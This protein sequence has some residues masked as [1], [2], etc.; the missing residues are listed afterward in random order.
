MLDFQIL[1]PFEVHRDGE[2]LPL[3]GRQQRALLAALVL[4]ANELVSSERLI[5][6]LW[7]EDPPDTADHLVHVY[8][9]RLRKALGDEGRDVLVT[10][11]P[12]YELLVP[13]GA[14]DLD[15]FEE[16]LTRARAARDVGHLDD[17]A[18]ALRDALALWRGPALADLVSESFARADAARLNELRIGAVEDLVEVELA[19]GDPDLVPQL[20][21]LVEE[22]PLRERLRGF[23][24]VALYREGRQAEALQAY[25]EARAT[26]ADELGIDPSQELQ[27]LYR[28]VLNQDPELRIERPVLR[29]AVTT[30]DPGS[31]AVASEIPGAAAPAP[32]PRRRRTVLVGGIGVL[33]LLVAAG[34]VAVLLGG[35]GDGTGMAPT[36]EVVRI[37]SDATDVLDRL[38][39]DGT[40]S[41]M[42]IDG[43]ILWIADPDARTITRVDTR[44]GEGRPYSA[45]GVPYAI[46]A[47]GGRAWVMDP[48][49]GTVTLIE[50]DASPR[51]IRQSHA[52]VDAVYA[53]DALWILD[54]IDESVSKI[55]P[56]SGESLA[57]IDLES[58]SGPIEIDASPDAIWVLNAL[59]RSLARIDPVTGLLDP[60]GVDL[61]CP[62]SA[63]GCR[64]SHLAVSD[65]LEWVTIEHAGTVELFDEDG[66]Q[67]ISVEG[68]ASPSQLVAW[69]E[70]AWI[71]MD[72]GSS[73]MHLDVHARPA[74]EWHSARAILGVASDGGEAWTSLAPP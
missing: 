30:A 61:Y 44:T 73:L 60:L 16:H 57:R 32:S 63:P 9:S 6:E 48:F 72:G 22:H 3:G 69:N 43:P 47:A 8:V 25:E 4:R 38:P 31:P 26:L 34:T 50:G 66:Q 59:D 70:G 27:D 53:F 41:A 21:S 37:S 46:E 55:D 7:P 17:A 54:A 62:P 71:V 1:G 64:P 10:R 68:W 65:D 13:A 29:A 40:P 19:R 24:M 12:G 42:T 28:R 14:R 52:P 49:G 33:A 51:V 35:D 20:R 2:P 18:S 23:L 11:Q 5:D 36:A 67:V 56:E 45:E 58:D 74:G 39:F 15:R